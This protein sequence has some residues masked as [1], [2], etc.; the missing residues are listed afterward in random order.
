MAGQGTVAVMMSVVLCVAAGRGDGC[1]KAKLMEEDCCLDME[2]RSTLWSLSATLPQYVTCCVLSNF[3]III[4]EE[5]L[6]IS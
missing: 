4:K 5:I 6:D 3:M 2:V 1:S